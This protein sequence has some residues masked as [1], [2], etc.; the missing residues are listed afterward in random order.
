RHCGRKSQIVSRGAP[1]NLPS[2]IVI[3]VAAATCRGIDPGI[4]VSCLEY[5][6][7]MSRSSKLAAHEY[8]NTCSDRS[9]TVCE[10][11]CLG[12]ANQP[13]C[14]SSQSAANDWDSRGAD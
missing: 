2:Y 11:K 4:I 5:A 8:V 12:R 10:D 9:V 3:R 1:C 6:A 14:Q 13:S 7:L